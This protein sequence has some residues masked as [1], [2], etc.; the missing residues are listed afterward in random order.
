[1]LRDGQAG[2]K[3]GGDGSAGHDGLIGEV[4][5]GASLGGEGH[6]VA[7]LDSP[8]AER[9]SDFA[10]GRGVLAP[11]P[12]PVSSTALRLLQSDA[13]GM[14]RGGG[15]QHR[16]DCAGA[17]FVWFVHNGAPRAPCAL[18]TM[19]PCARMSFG[20][21]LDLAK[22]TARRAAEL[23]LGYQAAGLRPEYKAD[24]SPVT[25]A[26][27]AC[28]KLIAAALEEAFPE[29]GILGEEGARK[30]SSSGRRWVIDPI[31][32]TRD[33]IRGG[34]LWCVMIGLEEGDEVKAGVVYLP[35]LQNTCWA[36]RG[37][38]AYRN[39]VRM[40]SSGV[41]SMRE[42]VLC[43]NGLNRAEGT[44]YGDAVL[45]WAASAWSVRVLGGT[46][47]AMMVAAGEADLWIEPQVAPW[48]L[49][50]PQVILEEAGAAFF[51]FKGVRTI[52]RGTAV[53]CAKG[54]EA[55]VREMF[56]GLRQD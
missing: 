8:G 41:T 21:E 35:M 44:A 9:D 52:H 3:C 42:A 49:A 4:K 26:D 33:F 56:A 14:L 45:T 7:L 17:H 47:D 55:K 34:P 20:R 37:E 28:E 54:L 53:G 2:V 13:I 23:A 40:R 18:R 32:G 38:G 27:R 31:D 15:F 50:A 39:G 19:L 24:Q 10:D 36:S 43:P 5:L 51:D 22:K 12:T 46:P 16:P 11:S 30:E 6:H 48:D 1:M 25:S 29:D